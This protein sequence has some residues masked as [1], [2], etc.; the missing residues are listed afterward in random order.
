M[1]RKSFS[2]GAVVAVLILIVAS[3]SCGYNQHLVS[4][5]ISPQGSTITLSGLGQQ[6]GTQFTAIGTYV[7]PPENRDLTS[8]AVWATD[9]PLIIA[10]DPNT[11]GLFN[12]TGTGCGT[13][14]G[15]TAKVYSDPSNPT[16]GSVVVGSATINVAFSSGSGIKCP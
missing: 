4:I 14:L 8:T 1:I 9:T 12:T 3:L 13:N 11:P 15:I 6:V 5:T 16:A 2:F 7:H 10:P